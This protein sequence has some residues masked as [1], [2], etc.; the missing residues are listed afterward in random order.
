[1]GKRGPKPKGNDVFLSVRISNAD[2]IAIDVL[3]IED[4]CDT[5]SD[6]LRDLVRREIAKRLKT[7]A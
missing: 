7:S 4:Q 3:A 6:W 2:R 1:M 5:A